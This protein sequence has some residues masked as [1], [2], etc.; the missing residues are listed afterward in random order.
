[1]PGNANCLRKIAAVSCAD[2]SNESATD[3]NM[4]KFPAD[5][6]DRLAP[7]KKRPAYLGNRLYHQHP[8]PASIITGSTVDPHATGVPFGCRYAD[9]PNSGV[10]VPHR[11]TASIDK[12]KTRYG[13][14]DVSEAKRLKQFEDKNSKL[15][16]LRSHPS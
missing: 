4:A 16:K 5:R 8:K 7:P 13:G 14:L 2:G 3:V 1:M 12:W 9:H 11:F 10:L 6:L 15:R